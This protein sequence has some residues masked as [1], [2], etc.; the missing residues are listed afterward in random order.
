[1]IGISVDTFGGILS[2]NIRNNDLF[3]EYVLISKKKNKIKSPNIITQYDFI[4]IS[5]KANRWLFIR[6]ADN[7][8]NA[9]MKIWINKLHD[10]K[11]V[12]ISFKDY[13]IS[14]IRNMKI[15]QVLIFKYQSE[16]EL[17]KKI[18]RALTFISENAD[19]LLKKILEGK[20]WFD[21]PFDWHN[22]K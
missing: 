9:E 2:N 22:Y 7:F 12:N 15:K 17:N 1:M 16:N 8:K 6:I 13:F 18:E 10:K 21:M 19:D 5:E 3:S 20:G 14:E 11:P 4:L